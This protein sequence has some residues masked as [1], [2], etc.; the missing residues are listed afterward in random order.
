MIKIKR[1]L[2]LPITGEPKQTIRPS[3]TSTRK[4]ALIG[5]DYVGLKPTML[6]QEGDRVKLGQPLFEDKKN[7]GVMFTSPASGTVKAIN[8]GDKRAFLSIEIELGPRA[9]VSFASYAGKDFLALRRED[10]R[11]NLIQ[12]GMWTAFRT[13]PFSRVPAP[14]S[15]PSAIFVPAI[16]TSPGAADPAVVIA[17]DRQAFVDGLKLL[18]R[19]TDGKVFV[20]HKAGAKIF[21]RAPDFVQIAEFDGPHPAG[22]VGTHIHFLHPVGPQR[23]VWHIGYQDVMAMAKLFA[24]GKLHTER[25]IALA[26]PKVKEPALVETQLGA[27]ISELVAHA[28]QPGDNRVISGSVLYGRRAVGPEAY[29]GRYHTQ[30]SVIDEGATREFL[31]WQKPGF[32]KFS[33]KRVYASWI[34]PWRRFA[35]TANMNG[36]HRAMVPVGAYERVMPLDIMPTFFLR[37]LLTQDVEQAQALGALELD[38]EDLA[39]F[40]FACPG[41]TDYGPL[42]RSVLNS[43]EKEG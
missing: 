32:D 17:R 29:L 11:D 12:S 6:V 5:S 40:T 23:T 16:D 20:C 14:Q 3:H 25:V 39:L 35:F 36:S 37:S 30:I 2:D 15:V 26:G 10:V 43:I 31:G 21:E 7:P 33:V 9:E 18:T 38:E 8:R 24:T 34:M 13:R 22:L 41:K 28:L 19:L 1:G 42:L 27:N 4:V